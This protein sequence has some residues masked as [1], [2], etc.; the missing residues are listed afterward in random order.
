M[1]NTQNLV[2]NIGGNNL[3]FPHFP[4]VTVC[5]NGITNIT[6]S[7][8]RLKYPTSGNYGANEIKCY[9]KYISSREQTHTIISLH[10]VIISSRF[11][12]C[13]VFRES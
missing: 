10:H 1:K 4:F 3:L 5:P 8:G 13:F 11:C 12:D 6:A 2:S 7:S 9:H